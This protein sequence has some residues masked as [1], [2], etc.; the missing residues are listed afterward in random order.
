VAAAEKL[1]K[2]T[3]QNY[4]ALDAKGLALCGLAVAGKPEKVES[5]L[6][7]FRAARQ[8]TRAAGIVARVRRLFNELL[9]ADSGGILAP[10][11]LEF[12]TNDKG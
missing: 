1:L 8:I 10:V 6:A 2:L 12:E 11:R 3:P 9:P 5:A 7:A 4:E